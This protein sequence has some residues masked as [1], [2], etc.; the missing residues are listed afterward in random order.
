[1]LCIF[2]WKMSTKSVRLSYR[3]LG[4]MTDWD[5]DW[6]HFLHL[7]VMTKKIPRDFSKKKVFLK[8]PWKILVKTCHTFLSLQHSFLDQTSSCCWRNN[9]TETDNETANNFNG[10]FSCDSYGIDASEPS[11]EQVHWHLQVI[12]CPR[13]QVQTQRPWNAIPIDSPS[14][15]GRLVLSNQDWHWGL[16]T[17]D[18]SH[19]LLQQR[20]NEIRTSCPAGVWEEYWVW[21]G[22]KD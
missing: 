2:R 13:H 10:Y 1:M 9:L 15:S 4:F 14:T 11:H 19:C 7:Q 8:N 20:L 5:R 18:S 17:H 22:H 3:D 12:S 6:N 21:K 16:E